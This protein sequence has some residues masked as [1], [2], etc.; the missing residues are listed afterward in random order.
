MASMLTEPV[1][2][3]ISQR[4]FGTPGIRS[5]IVDFFEAAL[6]DISR[7]DA[8]FIGG[9]GGRLRELLLKVHEYLLPGGTVV[10]NAVQETTSAEFEHTAKALGWHLAEPLKLKVNLHNEITVLKAVKPH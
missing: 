4:Q 1:Q 3:P 5:H 2:K 7:P 8:V 9:H 10:L 6:A